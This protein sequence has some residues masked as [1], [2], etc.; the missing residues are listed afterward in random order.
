MKSVEGMPNIVTHEEWLAARN[1]HLVKEKEMTRKLDALAAERR[2]LPIVRIG[3]SYEFEGPEGIISLHDLFEGRRQLVV[4]HFMFGPSW[5]EGCVGC[6]MVGDSLGH[7]AH[8]YARDT[9][10][11]FI[12]RAPLE[13][14]LRYKQRMGWNVPWYSSYGTDFNFDFDASSDKGENS[15]LSVF[16]RNG[17][18][19][20]LAYQTTARGVERLVFHTNILDMTPFGRQ[21]EWENSPDGW[22]QTPPY[23][24][25]RR[26]DEYTFKSS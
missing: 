23:V 26:H 24:W 14:L 18:T 8:L 22:P 11:V 19:V 15:L 17:D 25:W 16:L 20:Y 3:K 2:R 4:Y 12:S 7:P 13:K 6:S 10:F 9:S 5:D 1:E 21:E